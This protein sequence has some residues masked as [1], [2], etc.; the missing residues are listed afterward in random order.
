M[1]SSY[2]AEEIEDNEKVIKQ[3]IFVLSA[4]FDD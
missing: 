4:S 3:L 1:A 2:K